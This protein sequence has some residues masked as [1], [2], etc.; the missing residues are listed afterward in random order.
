MFQGLAALVAAGVLASQLP[1]LQEETLRGEIETTISSS[2]PMLFISVD[3]RGDGIADRGFLVELAAAPLD[4]ADLK[5]NGEI[6]WTYQ[7]SIV[8]TYHQ[9]K[10]QSKRVVLRSR[11]NERSMVPPLSKHDR[12]LHIVAMHRFKFVRPMSHAELAPLQLRR[13]LT[14]RLPS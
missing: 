10:G 3:E 5:V 8:L 12:V 7:D 6:Q 13:T 2:R 11:T 4:F 9:N 14:T 1:R